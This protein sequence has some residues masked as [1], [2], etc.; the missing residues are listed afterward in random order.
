MR[1]FIFDA[2]N[3]VMVDGKKVDLPPNDPGGEHE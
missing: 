1:Q 2:W 3:G